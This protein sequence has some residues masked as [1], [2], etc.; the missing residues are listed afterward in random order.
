MTRGR[1]SFKLDKQRLRSLRKEK[2]LS[3]VELSNAISTH[4]P[5]WGRG[6]SEA[7]LTANYQRIERTGSTSRKTA[8]AIAKALDVSLAFLEGK[9]IP[10][11]A[12]YLKQIT[13]LIG[14][15]IANGDNQALLSALSNL[16]ASSQDEG[17]EWLAED[18]SER[19]EAV[20]LGRNPAEI[21]DLVAYTG[22]SESE[23]LTPANLKGHWFITIASRVCNRSDILHGAGQIRWH[24]KEQ[25]EE[26]FN[27]TATDGTIRIWRDGYWYRIEISRP[28]HRDLMRIDFVR[29]QPDA[30][31]L[32]WVAQS[33]R[34]EYLIADPLTDWARRT[35][36]FVSAFEAPTSPQKIEQLRLIVTEHEG[37]YGQATGTELVTG[38]LDE[39]HIRTKEDFARESSSHYLV[40]SRLLADLR[41]RLEPKLAAYPRQYW[42][43]AG[44]HCIDL[45]LE[46][47]YSDRLIPRGIRYRIRL[48]EE[49]ASG[50]LVTAPW[51]HSDIRLAIEEIQSWLAPETS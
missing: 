24:I 46:P 30:N 10:D 5:N 23:L 13:K 39:I 8:E 25:V 36:N 51:R 19:I 48:E 32:R 12:D 43:V 34:D 37:S 9:E 3:L 18:I 42:R 44:D 26:D 2:G 47:P 16:N 20:Q 41:E 38:R 50:E 21:A 17:I 15:Q 40:V 31:G 29:C 33:W 27:E 28:S 1:P 22:L 6:S 45:H 4:Y 35:Y 49:L 7:T 14:E 11:S